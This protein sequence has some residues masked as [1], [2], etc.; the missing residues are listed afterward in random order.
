[1]QN[2]YKLLTPYIIVF[3]IFTLLILALHGFLIHH[4]IDAYLLHGANLFFLFISI[5]VF[6]IQKK[7]LQNKNPNVFIRSI[8]SGIIIKML[9]CIIAVLVYAL[10]INKNFSAASILIGLFIY[11]AYLSAE[12]MVTLKL[13][14]R[15]HG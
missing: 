2:S 7:A 1:M 5:L 10:A 15:H 12:V 4:G 8:M 3:I 14:K 6:F 11:M 13:N 9:L